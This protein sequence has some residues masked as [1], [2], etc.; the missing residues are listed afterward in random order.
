MKSILFEPLPDDNFSIHLMNDMEIDTSGEG[1]DNLVRKIRDY[2]I[3]F[4]TIDLGNLSL[5]EFNNTP[6]ARSLKEFEIPYFTIELPYYVKG[7]FTNQIKEIE[8][9]YYELKSTYDILVE[10]NKPAAQELKN[11]IDYYS[12]EL[13]KLDNFINL[14]VR[15]KLIFKKFQSLIKDKYC[16][17]LSFMQ[18]GESFFFIGILSF[19]NTREAVPITPLFCLNLENFIFV[20]PL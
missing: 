7:H 5:R 15:T 12:K 11:L 19:S 2:K 9:K 10:K 13:R 1:I 6:L 14:N 17:N 18:F 20:F 16:K 3:S 4:V 8:E